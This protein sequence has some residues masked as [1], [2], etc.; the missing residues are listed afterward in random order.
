MRSAEAMNEK[1]YQ[2]IEFA[3]LAGVT[4]RTLHH[5]L[6]LI[7]SG[8]EPERGSVGSAEYNDL[9]GCGPDATA[10]RF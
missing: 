2:A 6:P 5:M 4:V 1:Q 3:Q 9:L 8:S 7:V 10:F